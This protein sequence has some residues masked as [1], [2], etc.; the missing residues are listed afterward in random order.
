MRLLTFPQSKLMR[1]GAR[2][3]RYQEPEDIPD[4]FRAGA[5]R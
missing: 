2:D 4:T 3:Q 5:A 1:S